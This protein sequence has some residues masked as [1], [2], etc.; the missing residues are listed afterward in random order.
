M[1]TKLTDKLTVVKALEIPLLHGLENALE[2]PF[3]YTPS[4]SGK[5]AWTQLLKII[6]DK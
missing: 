5:G 6:R 2:I 4:W 3:S 1:F